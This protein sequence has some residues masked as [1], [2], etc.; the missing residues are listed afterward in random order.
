MISLYVAGDLIGAP[1]REVAAHLA[2]CDGCRRLAD[3][4]SE[5]RS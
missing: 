2:A 4:F 1:E 5:S 3:E